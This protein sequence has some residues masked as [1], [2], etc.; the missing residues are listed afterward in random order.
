M[1]IVIEGPNKSGKSTLLA[2]IARSLS[3]A[4][5]KLWLTREPGGTPFGEA[6]RSVVLQNSSLSDFTRALLMNSARAEHVSRVVEPKQAEGA[7]VICDRY[8]ASTEVFQCMLGEMTDAQTELVHSILA[9]FPVPD[10][11][12]FLLP[13]AELIRSRYRKDADRDVFEGRDFLESSAYREVALR[14]YE[15]NPDGVILIDLTFDSPFADTEALAA[16]I[17]RRASAQA[18]L[19]CPV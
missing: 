12:V 7:L 8:T 3:A 13:S 9:D 1:F 16:E 11:E 19:A 2:A 18:S 6:M 5:T 14:H 4:G 17:H 15:K 10:L